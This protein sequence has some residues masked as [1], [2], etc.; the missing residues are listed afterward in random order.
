[1]LDPETFQQIANRLPDLMGTDGAAEEAIKEWQAANVRAVTFRYP[2]DPKPA[3]P[4]VTVKYYAETKVPL[5]VL[6]KHL[7]CLRYQCSEE[8]PA[9]ETLEHERVLAHINTIAERVACMCV[10]E[11]PE[12]DQAPWG[13]PY[14]YT[15]TAGV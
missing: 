7:R 15:P 10:E 14:D 3:D 1:M 6:Y 11:L 9:A 12:Y 13:S 5:A 4:A 2:R 8:V